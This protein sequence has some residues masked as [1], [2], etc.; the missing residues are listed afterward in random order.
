MTHFSQLPNEMISEFWGYF[1]EPRDVENFTIVSKD[2]Y[3]IGRPFVEEHNK[4]KREYSIFETG[5]GTRA[6]APAFLLKDVLLRPRVAL[7][8]AHLSIGGFHDEWQ[9]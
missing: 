8:V 6:S 2:I 5:P 3:A 4:L 1:Q 7:Y 9:D